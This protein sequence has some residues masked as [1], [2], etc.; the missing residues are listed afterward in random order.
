MVESVLW[1]GLTR[2]QLQDLEAVTDPELSRSLLSE[3]MGLEAEPDV[4]KREILLD[5]HFYNWAFCREAAFSIKKSSVFME[6]MRQ[7]L[8]RD[9]RGPED[10]NDSTVSFAAFKEKLFIHAVERPPRSVSIFTRDDAH[11]IVGRRSPKTHP[12]PRS[13]TQNSAP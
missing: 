4:R 10:Y 7:T 6:L 12:A 5:F 11:R 3:F 2:Q 9:T 13:L 8:E 1:E